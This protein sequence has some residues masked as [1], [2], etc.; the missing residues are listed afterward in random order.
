MK[1]DDGQPPAFGQHA[2]AGPQGGGQIVQ[3]AIDKNAQRLKG[4]R[5]RVLARLARFH[6]AGHQL[7]QLRRL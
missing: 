6:R 7:R 3:L 4:A 5:G 1:A 2:Q